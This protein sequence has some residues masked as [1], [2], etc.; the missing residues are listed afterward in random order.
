MKKKD[1]RERRTSNDRVLDIVKLQE[2]DDGINVGNS[3]LRRS[4]PRL[5]KHGTDGREE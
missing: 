3:F 5:S 1:V 4:T 2:I